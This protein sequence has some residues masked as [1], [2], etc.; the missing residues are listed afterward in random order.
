MFF[1]QESTPALIKISQGVSLGIVTC[2]VPTSAGNFSLKILIGPP[3]VKGLPPLVS[4]T[5]FDANGNR[6]I[7]DPELFDAIDRWVAGQIS[8]Q[9]FF[10]VLDAW[11]AQAPI[12]GTSLASPQPIA[13]AFYSI[14][15]FVTFVARGQ[16]IVD[17]KV[18]VFDLTGQR[19]FSKQAR[20]RILIRNLK[21]ESGK[22]LANGVYL[23]VVTIQRP[24]GQ[25]AREL[26]KL[27]VLR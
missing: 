3:P 11:V 4:V 16:G 17:M 23:Y 22:P 7:D 25:I 21:S 10:A 14:R 15:G 13:L 6:L 8:D 27:A 2:S 9:L 19:I 12:H 20:G 1:D 18:E 5:Q 26:R 24:D